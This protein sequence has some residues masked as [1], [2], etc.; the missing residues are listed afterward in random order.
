MN[1]KIETNMAKLERT[2]TMIKPDAVRN[3]HLGVIID[4]I[5][6]AGFKIIALKMTQLSRRD[7]GLFYSEHEGKPFFH[8][9]VEYMVSGPIVV[10]IV[11][12]ENCI[13]DYRAFIGATDPKKAA[14]GTIR[15][16]YG[17]DIS[18]NAI[19]ASDSP[20]S[21]ERECKF[22]F[23]AREIYDDARQGAF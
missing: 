16:L 23:A 7:A 5:T 8:E 20:E 22:H 11:E 6:S 18:E 17:K 15:A 1:L 12:K 4:K 2:L 9:L 13:R 14:P 19:H 3:G 10:A 21:S